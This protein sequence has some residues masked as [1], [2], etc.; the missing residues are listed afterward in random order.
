M[1]A[2]L[3]VGCVRGGWV[4]GLEVLDLVLACQWVWL[5]LNTPEELANFRFWGVLKLVLACWW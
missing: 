2:C 4:V 3:W 1:L 5:A